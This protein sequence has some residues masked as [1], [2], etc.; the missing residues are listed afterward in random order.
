MIVD[1]SD[2]ARTSFFPDKAD[3]PLVIDANAPLTCPFALEAFQPIAGRHTQ[4]LQGAG[5]VQQAQLAQCNA[6]NVAGQLVAALALPDQLR[7][8]IGKALDHGST[9]TD[10]VT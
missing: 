2:I 6:L 1:N 4:V 10:H 8:G 9:I 7:L 5:G 3:A